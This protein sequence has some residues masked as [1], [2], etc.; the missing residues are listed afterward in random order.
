MAPGE[1]EFL[2]SYDTLVQAIRRA[3]GTAMA[4]PAGLTLSQYGLLQPLGDR[5]CARVSEL[6]A[7]AGIAAPTASRMLDV[8]ERRGLVERARPA[9][10]RRAVEV[11]LTRPGRELLAAEHEWLRGRQ[12]A[13][14]ASLPSVER[15]LAPDLLLRLAGLIDEIATPRRP[16]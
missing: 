4:S 14:Y 11:R 1:T 12:R 13:F 16:I 15:E 6:S 2:D 7:E 3:R 10:D 9:G 5:G 8:L